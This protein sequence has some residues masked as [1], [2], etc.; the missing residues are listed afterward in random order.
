MKKLYA[1]SIKI[2][3]LLVGDSFVHGNCVNRPNDIS[4][5]LRKLSNKPVLNLGYEHHRG[6]LIEYA[7]LRE[8]LSPKVKKVISNKKL[9]LF[10]CFDLFANLILRLF[11]ES[12]A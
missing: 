7:S 3:Y 10:R 9:S 1:M 11:G 2:E 6:P 5:V 8:Y 4:S 12:V